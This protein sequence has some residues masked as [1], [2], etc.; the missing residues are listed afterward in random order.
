LKSVFPDLALVPTGGVNLSNMSDYL[1]AGA[2]FVGVGGELFD[3]AD[4]RAARTG[5]VVGSARAYIERLR[6]FRLS[7]PSAS[8]GH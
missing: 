2:A 8:S 7:V 3:T 6:D 5:K 4:L 1:A